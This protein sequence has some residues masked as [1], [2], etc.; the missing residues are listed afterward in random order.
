[1]VDITANA[2][3]HILVDTPYNEAIYYCGMKHMP[4]RLMEWI[5]ELLME[6]ILE[7]IECFRFVTSLT[8]VC[9]SK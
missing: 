6:W 2:R 8:C 9:I 1:M 5:L 7:W 3:K 4:H